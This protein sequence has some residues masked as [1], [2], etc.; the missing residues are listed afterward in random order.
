[1]LTPE[2]PRFQDALR[3]ADERYAAR[4]IPAIVERRIRERLADQS[5]RPRRW[6]PAGLGVATVAA[7]ALFLLSLQSL[8]PEQLPGSPSIV[9][10]F[11]I[12]DASRDL[13]LAATEDAT[14]VIEAGE[15]QA[16]HSE[17]GIQLR[18]SGPITV[19]DEEDGLRLVRGRATF[20]V[21]KRRPAQPPAR[22]WVSHGRIEVL[23]TEF[24]IEQG[25]QGGEVK[26][27]EGAIRFIDERGRIRTL[28]PGDALRWPLSEEPQ[29]EVEA[30]PESRTPAPVPASARD[31]RPTSADVQVALVP[32]PAQETPAS[33]TPATILQELAKLRSRGEYT[34]AVELLRRTL[35]A[36]DLAA[37]TR[38]Q[39]SYELG[40]ILTNQ[41]RDPVA[42]CEHWRAHVHQHPSGRYATEVASAQRRLDCQGEK[43]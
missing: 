13:R 23:G 19:T 31:K 26:L 38:E 3:Q 8:S 36:E 42:A 43:P 16:I 11:A 2:R 12:D 20:A 39:L 5:R 34:K 21:D 14:L 24:T 9:A 25:A 18:N 40:T 7:A 17:H 33:A 10:G 41:I 6:V 28:E 37:A 1:M 15:C 22:I 30:T 35:Q 29:V 4:G 32:E 27:H